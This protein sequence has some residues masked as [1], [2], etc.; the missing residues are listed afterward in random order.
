MKLYLKKNYQELLLM[1][2]L[3]GSVVYLGYA[4]YLERQLYP[5]GGV[6]AMSVAGKYAYATFAFF[7]ATYLAWIVHKRMQQIERVQDWHIDAVNLRIK[8][9]LQDVDYV[10]RQAFEHTHDI[11]L[12]TPEHEGG[13]DNSEAA[14]TP[15]PTEASAIADAKPASHWP[16][17]NHHTETLGHLEAAAHKWWTLYEPSDPTTAPTNE[18]V[19]T[20]LHSERGISKEK[21]RAIASMLRADGLPT[22]PR[23]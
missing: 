17:G 7:M 15:L 11:I 22:G 1:A 10:G 4:G 2:G 23:R 9:L 8:K 19:A 3:L 20:W 6:H 18:T 13:A 14:V 16:W 12:D 5:S 21:A